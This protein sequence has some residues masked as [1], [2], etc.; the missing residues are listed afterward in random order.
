MT[1]LN[2][3]IPDDLRGV[4]QRTLLQTE[5]Q[6]DVPPVSDTGTWA[7][8]LQTSLWHGDLRVPELAL[9]HRMAQPLAALQPVQLAALA[10][11]QGFAGITQFEAL[12][13]GQICTWLR[14]ADY[15]PPGLQPDAG[16]IL[17]E[18]AHKLVEIGVHADYNE[19]WERL[20]DSVDRYVALACLNAD[21]RDTGVRLLVAGIYMMLVRPRAQRWPR[22][23]T[24]GY[25]LAD[26][27]ITF[28]EQALSWL[29]CEIS[30]GHIDKGH[31]HIERSTLPER[32]G[33]RW[34]VALQRVDAHLARLELTGWP[35]D[36]QVL[37]WTCDTDRLGS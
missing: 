21:G 16:W 15:Q 2:R 32:E 36:W 34:P 17:F 26:V 28:P 19:V 23:M 24:P 18:H 20:P 29:D 5:T 33:Q 11:Q 1:L 22:G 8:W 10:G 3:P 4:W 13:E 12:P 31:W 6:S 25:T 9:Q 7:R 27:V 30:F 37:E 35:A 14:R